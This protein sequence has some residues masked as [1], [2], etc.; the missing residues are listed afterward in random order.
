MF[1][2]VF[3]L[4]TSVLLTIVVVRPPDVPVSGHDVPVLVLMQSR[5]GRHE[6]RGIIRRRG[7]GDENRLLMHT[8]RHLLRDG[9]GC[10]IVHR[11]SRPV[12]VS[13]FRFPH[14]ASSRLSAHPASMTSYSATAK[15]VKPPGEKV[16]EI[17]AQ[18]SQV[19]CRRPPSGT[20]NCP[21][22]CFCALCQTYI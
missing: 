18:L 11:L 10:P 22:S 4:L 13:T 20:T 5:G 17:E 21:I 1:Q 2:S 14:P 7:A 19:S 3:L 6:E 9:S 12:H 8:Q 16:E 15:L